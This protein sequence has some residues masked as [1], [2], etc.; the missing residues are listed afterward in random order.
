L[1]IRSLEDLTSSNSG[2]MIPPHPEYLG[3]KGDHKDAAV[4]FLAAEMLI[5]A[6]A[7]LLVH[8]KGQADPA[9]ILLKFQYS[10]TL[11]R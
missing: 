4:W 6:G 1:Y 2:E 10:G 8:A 7:Q 5:E 11:V 9:A 3:R